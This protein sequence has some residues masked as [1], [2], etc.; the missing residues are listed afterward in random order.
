MGKNKEKGHFYGE[1]ETSSKDFTKT[2]AKMGMAKCTMRREYRF[3]KAN[4]K[5]INLYND[6]EPMCLNK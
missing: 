3:S 4:G 1:M 5:M 6:D 2:I